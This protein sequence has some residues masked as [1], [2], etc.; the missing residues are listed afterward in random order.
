MALE[1]NAQ[2]TK[3]LALEALSLV[4]QAT[5]NEQV[6]PEN[7]YTYIDEKLGEWLVKKEYAVMNKQLKN[8]KGEFAI[9]AT[10]AGINF[11]KENVK[12]STETV[13]ET[14]KP[15]FEIE[16]G[17]EMPKTKRGGNGGVGNKDSIQ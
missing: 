2:K 11:E 9:R 4:V 3:R 10:E 17:I 1:N 8:E 7:R 5:V 16:T 12:M 13:T 6:A 14:V 15:K